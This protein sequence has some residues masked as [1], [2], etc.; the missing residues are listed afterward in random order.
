MTVHTINEIVTIQARFEFVITSSLL[1]MK[2]VLRYAS[3]YKLM[4]FG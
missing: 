2:D 4:L 3:W 1:I